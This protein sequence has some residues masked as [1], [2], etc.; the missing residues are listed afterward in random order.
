MK[1][2]YIVRNTMKER[3]VLKQTL[4]TTMKIIVAGY[5]IICTSLYFFQENVIFFPEKLKADYQFTFLQPFEEVTVR[6]DENVK[7]HGLLF[8]SEA[9]KGV[10]FY[11][12]GN[13]GS[14]R[15][16]G[17]VAEPYTT[18]NY[19][20][21]IIDYRGYG[22]SGGKISNEDILYSDN[23]KAY[24]YLK[25]KYDEKQI[26]IL[27]YSIGTGPGAKLASDNNP[28][29]LILQAPYLNLADL[30]QNRF[31]LIPTFL[32]KYDFPTNKY[33]SKCQEPVVL[34][35]GTS[36]GVIYYGSSV[37]L[38]KGLKPSDTLI[39]LQNFGHNGMTSN[40]QYLE[41]LPRILR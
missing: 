27:G 14:L 15:K 3:S 41:A 4:L 12:H 18:L 29:K 25:T 19:D 24:E 17:N 32:L 31:P 34:I 10:I 13:A 30:M 21:F 22:K 33:A 1:N 20:V 38:R 40:P 5:L 2:F 37:K 36:D 8:R 39:T 23:Q 28:K 7:I 16:W 35:H 9:P 11:L 26:I 6:V